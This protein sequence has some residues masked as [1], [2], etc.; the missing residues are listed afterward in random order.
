MP[1]AVAASV[2]VSIILAEPAP[3][4]MVLTVT[5][6]VNNSGTFVNNGTVTGAMTVTGGGTLTGTGTLGSLA[7][8]SG[9]IYL[10]T[11]NGASASST[12]VIGN[13]ALNGSVTASALARIAT[14]TT[15]TILNAGSLTGT[16]T[17][18]TSA[19]NFARIARAVRLTLTL[20]AK[21][22]AEL[23]GSPGARLAGG[24]RRAGRTGTLE[25]EPLNAALAESE[26]LR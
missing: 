5:G 1:H 7:F 9:A 18:A 12:T 8:A 23:L 20:K 19:N 10:V 15:Y 17:G 21:A 24:A 13:A 14:T 11:L 16:F 3:I 2:L 4:A 25:T 6:N 22:R 26:P